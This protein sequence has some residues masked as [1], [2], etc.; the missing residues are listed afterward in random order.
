MA[1]NRTTARA[2][3]VRRLLATG[4]LAAVGAALLAPPAVPAPAEGYLE[5]VVVDPAGPAVDSET[6]LA[7]NRV[8][9][10]T[11][12]G[13]WRAPGIEAD[14]E[15]SASASDAS[16][17]R[18]RLGAFDLT[19]NG[20]DVEWATRDGA[21]GGCDATE[22]AY[23]VRIRPSATGPIRLDVP[24]PKANRDGELRVAV[25]DTTPPVAPTTTTTTSTTAAPPSTTSTTAP[26]PPTTTSTTAAPPSTTST[27]AG[28]T[29]SPTAAPT[30]STS[31]AAA[32]AHR[33][34]PK[35]GPPASSAPP[36]PAP[37]PAPTSTSAA[38]PTTTTDTPT[39]GGLGLDRLA[40]LLGAGPAP[41]A[42]PDDDPD[43]GLVTVGRDDPAAAE[44]GLVIAV[45]AF[46]A[47]AGATWFGPLHRL[48]TRSA[49]PL[50]GGRP[51]RR[52]RRS[53][54]PWRQVEPAAHRA[55]EPQPWLD[56]DDLPVIHRSSSFRR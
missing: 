8:Y 46:L 37:A 2:R 40:G 53:A 49:G 7:A 6:H 29:T 9:E 33:A 14:A 1:R 11:V 26:P 15:C 44:L 55:P 25:V 24:G 5:T 19:V 54:T 36:P 45:T 22:H 12:T 50:A 51:P 4:G 31:I 43:V 34:P 30:T 41:L 56:R 28:P 23:R 32:T 10:L 39:P 13:T 38:P 3:L 18:S 35:A 42:P 17:R 21:T 52:T 47:L 48:A 20:V 16:W 27:T